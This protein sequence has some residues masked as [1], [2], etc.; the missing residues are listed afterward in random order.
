MLAFSLQIEKELKN[1]ICTGIIRIVS[2]LPHLYDTKFE[3]NG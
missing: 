3:Q 1:R 2:I